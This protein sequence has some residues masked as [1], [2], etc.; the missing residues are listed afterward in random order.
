[1]K[2]RAPLWLLVLAMIVGAL[3]T[4]L[5]QATPPAAPVPSSPPAGPQTASGKKPISFSARSVQGVLAKDKQDTIL[6]GSVKI[7]T[8]SLF[9]TAD[10]VEL[11]GED[12]VNVACSGNVTVN[13]TEK[14]F[15]LVAEKLNYQRDT[16]IGLAQGKVAVNDTK[17]NTIID[18]EWIR[19]DQQQS[20]FEAAVSVLV[21]KEDMSIR[22]EYAHY[23][24]DTEEIKL[25]GGAIAVTEEGTLKGDVI[26][27]T[28]DWSN[29]QISGEVSG[30]ITSKENSASQ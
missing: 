7:I 4:G 5:A 2:T 17:N 21:L 19:F 28:S 25:H 18:A 29:L 12:Y 26:S 15:S 1:M 10:R 9:I 24:R 23:N 20:I 3:Q 16:E 14:G 22:A 13:D 27:A 8:G 30:N 6:T 11:S